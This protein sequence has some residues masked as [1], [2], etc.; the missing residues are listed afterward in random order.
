MVMLMVAEV[1]GQLGVLRTSCVLFVFQRE[2]A[3]QMAGLG[4]GALMSIHP[5][6]RR[7]K[8]VWWATLLRLSH[9]VLVLK[10]KEKRL[11]M[12][13][14]VTEEPSFTIYWWGML[15]CTWA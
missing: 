7:S 11:K 2:A 9:T 14:L 6:T 3:G 8:R 12:S 15:A 10:V 13:V 4:E 1:E 5:L